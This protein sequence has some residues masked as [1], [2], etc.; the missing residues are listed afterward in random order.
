MAEVFEFQ[1]NGTMNWTAMPV[2]S[3]NTGGFEVQVRTV[4][5]TSPFS[6]ANLSVWWD[7]NGTKYTSAPGQGW[8]GIGGTFSHE[9][10]G[11]YTFSFKA[12]YSQFTPRPQDDV[13]L[14]QT[15]TLVAVTNITASTNHIAVGTNIVTLTAQMTPVEAGQHVY[16]NV[17][18][19]YVSVTTNQGLTTT[20]VCDQPGEFL[21]MAICGSSF[22]TTT[23]KVYAVDSVTASPTNV[24]AGGEVTFTATTIPANC[25]LPLT[26]SVGTATGLSMTTNF[27]AGNHDV[28]VSLGTSTQTV[29]VASVGVKEIKYLVDGYPQSWTNL[30]T[31]G[32]NA[33]IAVGTSLQVMAVPDPED[34]TFPAGQ[35]VWSDSASGTGPT[36][37]ATFST[38]SADA[39]DFKLVTATSGTS[40]NT[41]QALVYQIDS[42]NVATNQLA[43]GT[44]TITLTAQT[45][46][47]GG[48]HL[49]S[50]SYA[51]G[52]N[53]P[54]SVGQG[55][56]VSLSCNQA[57]T[58]TFTAMCGSSSATTNIHI[59]ALTGL[60]A[61]PTVVS[62]GESVTFTA[63]TA[64]GN[65]PLPLRWTGNS[66]TGLTLTTN[67]PAGTHVVTVSLGTSTQTVSVVSVGVKEIQYAFGGSGWQSWSNLMAGGVAGVPVGRILQVKALPEPDGAAFPAGKPVWSESASGTGPEGTATFSSASADASDFKKVTATSGTSSKTEQTLVFKID[68]ILA[69][70]NHVAIGTNTLLLTAQMTPAAGGEHLVSWSYASGT[71]EAT[72]AGQAGS[73]SFTCSQFGSY[74]FTA[75]CGSSSATKVINV[76]A[77]TGLSLST[78]TAKLGESVTATATVEP[79]GNPLA[80]T[81]TGGGA[82]PADTGSTLTITNALLGENPIGVSLGSSGATNLLTVV[83]VQILQRTNYACAGSVV[84]AGFSL[85]NS[86]GP[87]QWTLTPAD[88]VFPPTLSDPSAAS[89]EITPGQLAGTFTVTCKSSLRPDV[90]DTATLIVFAIRPPLLVKHPDGGPFVDSPAKLNVLLNQSATFKATNL[91]ARPFPSDVPNW[92][93]IDA[94]TGPNDSK[95]ITF[96]SHADSRFLLEASTGLPTAN[97]DILVGRYVLGLHACGDTNGSSWSTFG[98]A[99]VSLDDLLLGTTRTYGLWSDDVD[100]IV[101]EGL[102]N[103]DG[104][105]VRINL[106]GDLR[107]LIA[108]PARRYYFLTPRQ[109]LKFF[110]FVDQHQTYNFLLNNCAGWANRL[111]AEVAEE[112]VGAGIPATPN[113]LASNIT[114]IESGF[115]SSQDRPVGASFRSHNFILPGF[116]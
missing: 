58:F 43:I 86:F 114:S 104:T 69:A 33:G 71:N 115:E 16:W 10:P 110:T 28:S 53:A 111:V 81:W 98:H 95:T 51:R 39:S 15:I 59:Y 64:P 32:T 24:V 92:S 60:S 77:V 68:S 84:T 52:T 97:H 31:G 105:D 67:L 47:A 36:A 83:N 50:W 9:T 94:Y 87:V 107:Y 17:P 49:V 102:S 42:I 4:G 40:S 6:W 101:S 13:N 48:G 7:A 54:T 2:D 29:S 93:Y 109:V 61:L 20:L 26:W 44:N 96:L 34:A 27:A 78:N 112:A 37:T 1:L 3:T 75:T 90:S 5:G 21:I 79:G 66:A 82:T 80:L 88:A 106:P 89:V 99:V 76:Y 56:G 100:G 38:A 116:D 8:A 91:L 22:A 46:P 63:T 30:M 14:T 23:I 74:T 70:T 12:D 55:H 11:E 35:P 57:G 73:V 18:N 103:G 108:A 19:G 72:A 65:C 62:A 41:V 45:T 85:T 113:S 25:P